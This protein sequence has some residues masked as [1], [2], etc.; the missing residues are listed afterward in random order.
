MEA[1]HPLFNIANGATER[2]AVT[3]KGQIQLIELRHM[4]TVNESDVVSA[5]QSSGNIRT[6]ALPIGCRFYTETTL[7]DR[8]DRK[9]VIERPPA[10]LPVTMRHDGRD[11]RMEIATPYR[12]Y[13]F[14]QRD[15]RSAP[16]VPNTYWSKKPL[17]SMSDPLYLFA[18]PNHYTN[19]DQGGQTC[20]GSSFDVGQAYVN[21]DYDLDKYVTYIDSYIN[22]SR[23]NS[24][25]GS[26][27]DLT[28]L[29]PAE[30][31][32]I[33]VADIRIDEVPD[34]RILEGNSLCV[35]M[36]RAHVWTKRAQ[37]PLIDVL[38]LDFNHLFDLESAR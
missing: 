16:S 15:G 11:Y 4:K 37:N 17:T 29:Q 10:I 8:T 18:F 34:P 13:T 27:R 25:L 6:P 19:Q 1:N 21:G 38:G 23:Y 35:A 12:I 36:A 32:N 20:F 2:V 22:N 28:A 3:H 9:F 31:R 24:D 30:W 33:R 26:G 7:E 5:L 14:Y